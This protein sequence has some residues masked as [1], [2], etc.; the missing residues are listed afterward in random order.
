MVEWRQTLTQLFARRVVLMAV[1]L[2][3]LMLFMA[4]RLYTSDAAD[5]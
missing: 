3:G 5:E 1:L 4:C 2:L